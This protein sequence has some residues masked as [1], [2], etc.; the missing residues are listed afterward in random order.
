M[1]TMRFYNP[2]KIDINIL[3]EKSSK[4]LNEFK[5]YEIEYKGLS[6]EDM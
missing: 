6:L 1:V 2:K 3:K 4:L 5:G